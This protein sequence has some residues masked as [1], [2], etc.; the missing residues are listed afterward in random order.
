MVIIII[1]LFPY[2]SIHINGIIYQYALLWRLTHIEYF[3]GII[4]FEEIIERFI[5]YVE[6]MQQMWQGVCDEQR[7]CIMS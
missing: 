3:L 6:K 5:H 2:M 7:S 4:R 1:L